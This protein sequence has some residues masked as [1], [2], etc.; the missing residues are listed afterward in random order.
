MEK[1][2]SKADFYKLFFGGLRTKYE[3]IGPTNKG[4]ATSTYSFTTFD[5]VDRAIDLEMDY[6]SNM[7]SPKR[8]YFPD[9]QLLYKY[10]KDGQDVKLKDLR[11]VWEKE[12]VI[13]GLHPCDIAAISRL[14]RVL[15]ENSFVDQHY[16]DK[17]R[18]SIIIGLTCNEAQRRCFCNSLGSGPDIE[19]GYDLLL[20][21]IGDSYFFRAGTDLGKE[22]ISADYFRDATGQDRELREAKLKK[23]EKGLL[24]KIDVVEIVSVM[25]DKYND[26]LWND[27]SM[28]CFTCGACNMICPTCHCFTVND[29]TSV[30]GSQGTRVIVWDPCHFARFAQM[31]G[32]FNLREEKS[33]RFK[34]RIYDKFH[35]SA[36]R[37][38]TVSCVGC[39]RCMEFCP[40]H[41]D[42]R[43]ALRRL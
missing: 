43:D 40:S 23:V 6:K 25:A 14:D 18:K 37:Y 39:G 36:K 5:Y 13:F 22:L 16:Q 9:N 1:V 34:H 7:L 3:V 28:K 30:D 27:F 12:K 15:M 17:R 31:A 33:S 35:Y 41:I 29:K 11:E 10:K 42:I 24:D 4:G 19:N 26:E 8:I 21:D 32:N 2:L 38:G 20:T